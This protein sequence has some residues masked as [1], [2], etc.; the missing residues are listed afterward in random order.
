[1]SDFLVGIGLILA[2]E[3]LALAALPAL[4]KR[5]LMQMLEMPDSTLRRVGV[6]SAALGVAV[7]WCIRG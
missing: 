5:A 2:V 1:M 7:V 4:T 3:G 6:G